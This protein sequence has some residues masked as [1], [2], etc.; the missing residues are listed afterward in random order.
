MAALQDSLRV[1][2]CN[3]T[4]AAYIGASNGDAPEFYELF[5]AAMDAVNLHES[6]MIR[7]EFDLDDRNFLSTA[8]LVLLAG[9][10]VDGGFEIIKR[11][12]MD[13]AVVSRYYDGA[14][15]VGVSAGAM[16]LGMGWLKR[17][18]PGT[19]VGLK[20]VPS[21]VDVH[22]ER[23]DWRHLRQLIE[24]QEEYAKG[25]GIPLGGG[26]IFHADM[27]IE[28]MHR[29]V[30]EFEKSP[31]ENSRMKSNLLL[32]AAHARSSANSPE[33]RVRQTS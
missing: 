24:A 1:S 9:G 32:P 20:L 30:S 7:A 25:F 5:T 17:D 33:F 15:L 31:D 13:S 16:Q 11:N 28:A 18:S 21:Y 10:D 4:K 23:N 14:V 29:P 27:S 3:I 22:G 26:L 12:G 19:S 8:D 6:R 2:E